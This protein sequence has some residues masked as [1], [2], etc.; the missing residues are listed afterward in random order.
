M[1]IFYTKTG[2]IIGNIEGRV[3]SNEHLR[4]WV[5]EDTERIVCQWVQKDGKFKPTIQEDIFIKLDSGES[6]LSDFKVN[7]KTKELE[8]LS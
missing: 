6:K 1:I 7:T 8:P 5:G 2:E 3:H 4:M